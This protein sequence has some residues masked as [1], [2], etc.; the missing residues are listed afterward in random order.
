MGFTK[1][2]RKRVSRARRAITSPVR[3]A[4]TP[5]VGKKAA[6]L[7]SNPGGAVVSKLHRVTS[8]YGKVLGTVYGVGFGGIIGARAVANKPYL[9]GKTGAAIGRA[10]IQIEK[11]LAG[12]AG[13]LIAGG[14][15]S[16]IA[17]GAA[18]DRGRRER[19][20][21]ER[22]R[23]RFRFV[24]RRR[25]FAECAGADARRDEYDS[26]H[27]PRARRRGRGR[28][29][30]RVHEA[31]KVTPWPSISPTS[32]ANSRTSAASSAEWIKP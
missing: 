28:R 10:A 3:K 12:L 2:L 15:G 30:A 5:I 32:A 23:P 31:E 16:S 19:R 11:P 24:R 22:R 6:D 8:A 13:G 4:L 14:L 20:L 29:L 7:L 25:L 26:I 17:G 21:P 27:R 18:G 9:G 1:R